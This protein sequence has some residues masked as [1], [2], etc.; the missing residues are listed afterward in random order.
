MQLMCESKTRP[1]EARGR[2][3]QNM[4]TQDALRGLPGFGTGPFVNAKPTHTAPARTT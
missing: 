3:T 4:V 2:A 1:R